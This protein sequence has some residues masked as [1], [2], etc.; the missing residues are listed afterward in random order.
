FQSIAPGV[1]PGTRVAMGQK[2]G[3]LGKAGSSGGRAHLHFDIKCRQPSGKWGIQEGYAFI[4]E[5]YQREHA[6][7]VVAVAR[8]HQLVAVGAKVALDGSRSFS[9]RGSVTQYSWTF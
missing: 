4:W 7:A 5:A 8:P 9:A 1:R 3:V 6:P 2:I